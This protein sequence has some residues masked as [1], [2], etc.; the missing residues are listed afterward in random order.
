MKQTK[1]GWYVA[2]EPTAFEIKRGYGCTHYQLAGTFD[3]ET[4]RLVH[5]SEL[6]GYGK[7]RKYVKDL[8]MGHVPSLGEKHICRHIV[9]NKQ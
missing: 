1:Q 5:R 7:M 8:L 2:R 4:I 6:S 9:D 3:A